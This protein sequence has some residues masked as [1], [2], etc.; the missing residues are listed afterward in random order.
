M[1]LSRL[2]TLKYPKSIFAM[3]SLSTLLLSDA[4][5]RQV[6]AY[7]TPPGAATLM[8]RWIMERNPKTVLEPSFGDGSFL[9]AIEHEA[10]VFGQKPS[11]FGVELL[12]DAFQ[13]TKERLRI[14]FVGH[15]G[16]FLCCEPPPVDAVIGNPPFVRLRH[17]DASMQ[18][19]ALEASKSALGVQMDPSGSTWMPFVLHS[20]RSLRQNGCLALVLP[21]DF[22]YVR[23]ARP[24]WE[25][26]GANFGRLRVVRTRSRMFE[27]LMQDVIILLADHKGLATDSVEF[28]VNDDLLTLESET[29][30]RLIPIH[31][32]IS[33]NRPFHYALLSQEVQELVRSKL[34]SITSPVGEFADVHIG[35]VSGDKQ[36]FHPDDETV[37]D[38]SLEQSSILKAIGPTRRLQKQGLFTSRFADDATQ[39]LWRPTK[40]KACGEGEIRY[41]EHGER[42]GVHLRYKCSVRDPWYIVPDIQVPDV[43]FPVFSDR[44]SLYIND[45]GLAA[46]N[47]MICGRLRNGWDPKLLAVGWYSS[48]TR[49]F[50]ELEVHSL[51]GGVLVAV[52]RELSKVRIPYQNVS[53]DLV[54]RIDKALKKGCDEEAVAVG[55][56]ALV[57][58]GLLTLEE[59]QLIRQG[60]EEMMQWRKRGLSKD[61]KPQIPSLESLN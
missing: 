43:I 25:Y 38:Y 29:D 31:A 12:E 11:L 17:L 51:G 7:F 26:L 37:L 34:V 3:N 44:P 52:P 2:P 54:H 61:I 55:D 42:Q 35:Y 24:L 33:G 5:R 32:A 15:V 4:D 23:Y 47:S 36:F 46:S 14:P 58:A 16:D 49:L 50:M 30:T 22:T 28:Q 53:I 48:L 19:T 40:G 20:T 56:A 18:K 57:S 39:N 9:A 10:N 1:L 45:G 8:A 21:L 60:V 27:S 6:G 59:T 13:A 41:V